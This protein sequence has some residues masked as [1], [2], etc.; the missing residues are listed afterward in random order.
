MRHHQK[1]GRKDSSAFGQRQS[2]I[3]QT[4]GEPLPELETE[5]TGEADELVP[6][7]LEGAS[8]A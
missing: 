1:S 2:S 7:L 4:E 6:A 8:D 3:F 5:A